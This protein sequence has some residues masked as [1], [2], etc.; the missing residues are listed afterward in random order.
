MIAPRTSMSTQT[1]NLV[2]E[3]VADFAS[4]VRMNTSGDKPRILYVTPVWPGKTATGV[5][6]RALNVL[7][8]L[9]QIGAVEVIVLGDDY[10]SGAR[11]SEPGR[12][13]KV[14]YS[15]QL[16]PRPSNGFIEKLRW[17]LD[18][19][20]DYPYGCHAVQGGMDR[21]LA[22]ANQFDLIW[23]FKPRSPGMFPNAIWPRSVL[24]I[25]DLESR[26]EHSKLRA[27]NGLLEDFLTI[28]RQLAWKRRE[29]LFGD[30]FT[31]LTVC[32]EDDREYLT[33]L[34]LRV[35]I[36]VVPNGFERP[37]VE[38]IRNVTLPPRIGFMAPFEYFPNRDG[39]QWFVKQCWPRVKLQ[40]PDARLRLAGPGSDGPL[41]PLGTDVDGL[42][43]LSSPSDEIKTWS[44][45]IVPIRVGGGTRVKIAYG[46]SQ[47]CPIVSTSLGAYGYR[48]QSGDEMYLADSAEAF[49]DAC[50]GII[51]EPEK[52]RQM[53]ERAWCQYLKKWTWEAIHP[54]VWA[55]A[56]DCLRRSGRKSRLAH[57]RP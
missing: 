55:A 53:A 3:T 16:T 57:T 37:S 42:G 2:P 54:S 5:H 6:V 56:E 51:R 40:V 49:A 38:P 11:F 22:T 19:T 18:P 33:H 34:G 43:W 1:G 45:M 14:A 39:I 25:D 8:A 46:F 20:A 35:P 13:I 47:K 26:W 4:G 32:S 44:L 24:D 7:R 41:K 9:Q 12:E 48:A 36:H 29:K 23:F 31:V 50:V 28:R 15:I 21:I 30:R 27:G 17:T 52:A 10:E